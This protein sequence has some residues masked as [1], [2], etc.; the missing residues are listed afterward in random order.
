MVQTRHRDLHIGVRARAGR[1]GIVVARIVRRPAGQLLGASDDAIGIRHGVELLNGAGHALH[2][3]FAQQLQHA[4]ELPTARWR[5]QLLLE[6]GTQAIERGRQSPVAVDRRMIERCDATP[7]RDQVVQRI[8]DQLTMPVAANMLRDDAIDEDNPDPVDGG[9]DRHRLERRVARHAVTVA[10][11]A[12][13][14]ILV[15]LRRGEHARLERPRGQ[16]SRR[17]AVVGQPLADRLALTSTGAFQFLL[18]A[19]T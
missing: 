7:Q 15:H 18:A 3:M 19:A 8:Q 11:E 1:D 12:G 2:R 9:L 14:L 5:P 4:D 17:G 13:R 6:A 10:V 16:R